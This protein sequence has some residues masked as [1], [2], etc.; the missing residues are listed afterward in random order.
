M[1]QV[2]EDVRKVS[3]HK[4]SSTTFAGALYNSDNEDSK[5]QDSNFSSSN[6]DS[7]ALQKGR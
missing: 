6:P 4:K 5:H 3:T 1:S 2:S 7:G